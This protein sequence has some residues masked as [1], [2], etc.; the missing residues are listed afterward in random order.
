V[1]CRTFE[2][3]PGG[4]LI[5]YNCQPAAEPRQSR[6]TPA[7]PEEKRARTAPPLPTRR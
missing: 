1:R 3:P 6:T 4:V 5:R 7:P 2:G